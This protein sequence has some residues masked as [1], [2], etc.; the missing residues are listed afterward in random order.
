MKEKI[1][2]FLDFLPT[3]SK[4][5]SDFILGILQWSNEDKAAFIFAKQIFEEGGI[6]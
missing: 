5:E 2:K 6:K 3:I 4:H 1:E